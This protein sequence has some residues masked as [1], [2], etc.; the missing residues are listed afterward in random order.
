MNEM[1]EM[2]WDGDRQDRHLGGGKDVLRDPE[3]ACDTNKATKQ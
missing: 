3:E 1:T 2:K